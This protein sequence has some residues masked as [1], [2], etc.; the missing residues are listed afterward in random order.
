MIRDNDFPCTIAQPRVSWCV[1]VCVL[2]FFGG[3]ML[4]FEALNYHKIV[5]ITRN[6]YWLLFVFPRPKII[7]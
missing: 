6:Q 2:F 1:C 3:G 4:W 7:I 5:C